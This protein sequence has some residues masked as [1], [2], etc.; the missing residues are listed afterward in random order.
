MRSQWPPAQLDVF[1]IGSTHAAPGA[2]PL[3][4]RAS[5]PILA[6]DRQRRSRTIPAMDPVS[7]HAALQIAFVAADNL[8]VAM[9]EK[10]RAI[11]LSGPAQLSLDQRFLLERAYAVLREYCFYYGALMPAFGSGLVSFTARQALLD[12]MRGL[13]GELAELQRMR[14]ELQGE[15]GIDV[16]VYFGTTLSEWIDALNTEAPQYAVEPLQ[17][18]Q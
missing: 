16:E 5:I 6:L 7:T 17:L 15:A 3:S 13:Y 1:F 2:V 12:C 18:P 11:R 9:T 10:L 8:G 4:R 14:V